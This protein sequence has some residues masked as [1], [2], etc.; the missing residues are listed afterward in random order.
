MI[1]DEVSED[2]VGAPGAV[3]IGAATA[4]LVKLDSEGIPIVVEENEYAC[5]SEDVVTTGSP[6]GSE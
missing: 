6:N 4:P 5:P 2:V 1:V 3:V